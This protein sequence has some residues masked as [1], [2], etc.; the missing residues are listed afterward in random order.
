MLGVI[1]NSFAAPPAGG[2]ESAAALKTASVKRSAR[3]DKHRREDE[4]N[5]FNG[6]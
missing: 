6:A 1:T 2:R 3:C 4:K 5:R